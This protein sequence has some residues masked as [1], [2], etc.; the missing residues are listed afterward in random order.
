MTAFAKGSC[1]RYRTSAALVIFHQHARPHQQILRGF[2]TATGLHKVVPTGWCEANA[3]ISGDLA[4]KTPA[5]EVVHDLVSLGVLPQR[6][7]IELARVLE[8][9]V[10]RLI[11]IFRRFAVTAG[12]KKISNAQT[13]IILITHY[14]RLLDEIEPNYVHV[15][16]DGQIIKTG[17]SDLALELEKKGYEWTDNFVKE[18]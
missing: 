3:K 10:E 12:V 4:C 14:Q 11:L 1:S 16:A 7:L 2:V 17:G 18:T 13:G 8:R 15:M 9:F 6:A 5:L